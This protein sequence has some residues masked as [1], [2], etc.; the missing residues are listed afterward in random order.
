M[1][2]QTLPL[3][4]RKRRHVLAHGDRRIGPVHHQQVD[5]VDL[6]RGEARIDRAGKVVGPEILV[7]DL[8]GEEDV[9]A[10]Q[11]RRAHRLGDGR[12]GAVFARGIDM[13]IAGAQRGEHRLGRQPAGQRRSAETD[14]RNGAFVVGERNGRRKRHAFHGN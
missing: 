9:A 1:A 8:G 5:E 3:G 7:A 14:A 4:A 6:E 13:A 12:L 11:T 10:R 2:R